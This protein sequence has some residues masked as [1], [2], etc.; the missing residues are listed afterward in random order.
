MSG[1]VLDGT[2]P[3]RSAIFPGIVC[4]HH[5]YPGF[6]LPLITMNVNFTWGYIVD[7]HRHRAFKIGNGPLQRPP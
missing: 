5:I 6:V 1:W 3:D 2:T 4:L 7:G